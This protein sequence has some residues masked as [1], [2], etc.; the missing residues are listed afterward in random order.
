MK[1]L[2]VAIPCYNSSEYMSKC[3]ESL[4]P[5]GDDIE[6]LIVDDGSAKD[7]TF[8]IARGYEEK[9]PG[10]VRAIHQENAGHGGAVNK[11]IQEATGIYF[12][13]ID[14]DDWADTDV[15]LKIIGLL[16]DM[17]Q[18]GSG[19]DLF[20]ANFVFD[21]VGV[22]EENKK[23]MRLVKS[24]PVGKAFSWGEMKGSGTSQYIMM[25][26]VIYR[27][28]VL[29]KSGLKLPE[30]TFYC[31]NIYAYQ[32][33]PYVSKIFYLD[34]ALYR[35][36]IGREG[37]SVSVEAQLK[38]ID[39]QIRV[40]KIMTDVY[41]GQDL[42]KLDPKL[43]KYMIS[44]LTLMFCATTS[45]LLIGGTD[46]HLKKKDELWR[47][48]EERDPRAYKKVKGSFMG[49]WMTLPGRLGRKMSV[50]GYRIVQKLYKFN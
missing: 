8:E 13:N 33:L 32:P 16:K 23:V 6:I 15:L 34:E 45:I 38:N 50:G 49:G 39:Q 41:A 24:M 25:H 17:E 29:I 1:I 42:S 31:D 26:N 5:A 46:E 18:D 14:S 21:K 40:D 27:R 48:L 43:A 10:I 28:D 4:L 12:K 44:Y 2:S 9:Y 30:H 11:G 7:N 36:Y 35:Y 20:L 19:V 37:Q 47:Y 3:I 22:K